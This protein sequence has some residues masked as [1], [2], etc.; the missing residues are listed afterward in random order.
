MSAYVIIYVEAVTD[1]AALAEYRRIALPTL[2]ASK[3]RFLVRNGRFEALE[4]A[5]P[6]SVLMLEFPT[7]EDARAWYCSPRYQEALQHR[8]AGARCSIVLVQGV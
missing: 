4:G 2:E 7:M 5:A 3:G 6:Q 8:L 1:P